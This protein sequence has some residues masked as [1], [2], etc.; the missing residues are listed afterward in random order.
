MEKIVKQP[1]SLLSRL[2]TRAIGYVRV[3]TEKQRDEGVSLEVQRERIRA[4]AELY[5]VEIVAWES[6]EGASA[7]SLERPGLQRALARLDR[8]EANAILV[9]KLDRLTRSVRDLGELI[10]TYF[11]DGTNSLLSVGEQIDT[12]SAA[13]RMMLN[14]LTV[15]SQWERET[16][17]ERTSVAMQHKKAQ[18]FKFGMAR[19]GTRIVGGVEEAI[20]EEQ[21]IIATAR[22]LRA[23][24]ASL[25]AI[26]EALPPARNGKRFKPTQIMRML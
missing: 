7:K 6:D 3:S 18:G 24:G 20:P 12:R 15:V 1:P 14:I 11:E 26:A 16:I 22:A 19:Y 25:R 21:G 9:F 13:G 8:F 2:V 10:E 17:G 5:G 4:Y 23:T